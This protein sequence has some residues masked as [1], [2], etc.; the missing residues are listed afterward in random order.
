MKI[1]IFLIKN[2]TKYRSILWPPK[3]HDIWKKRATISC[4]KLCVVELIYKSDLLKKFD[5][6]LYDCGIL[7]YMPSMTNQNSILIFFVYPFIS[8]LSATDEKE[9]FLILLLDQALIIRKQ[10]TKFRFLTCPRILQHQFEI[11]N[12]Q[13]QPDEVKVGLHIAKVFT[14]KWTGR[15]T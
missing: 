9:Q 12:S 8:V 1:L 14:F 11:F 5:R 13:F 15:S 7:N 10:F 4:K 2:L 6:L 3:G